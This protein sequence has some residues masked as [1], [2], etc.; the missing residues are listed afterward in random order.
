MENNGNIRS[1]PDASNAEDNTLLGSGLNL[2][3]WAGKKA[4]ENVQ[5]AK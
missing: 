5:Y 4:N 1:D 3:S 2:L